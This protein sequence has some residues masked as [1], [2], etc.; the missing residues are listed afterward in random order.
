MI[1][2]DPYVLLVGTSLRSARYGKAKESLLSDIKKINSRNELNL[3]LKEQAILHYDSFSE[4][5]E[6]EQSYLKRYQSF[7]KH[8][9]K[10]GLSNSEVSLAAP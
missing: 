8:Q 4:E 7:R 1:N 10:N 3:Y 2:D 6:S 9:L 5:Y